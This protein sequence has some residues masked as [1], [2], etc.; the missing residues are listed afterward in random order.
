MNSDF[1]SRLRRL[2]L[3]VLAA[4]CAL[5]RWPPRAPSPMATA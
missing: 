4:T 3:A 1:S 2:P 5:P